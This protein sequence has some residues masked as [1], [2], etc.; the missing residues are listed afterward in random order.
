MC[1]ISTLQICNGHSEFAVLIMVILIM[2]IIMNMIKILNFISIYFGLK[3][4]Q[5]PS[6][7]IHTIL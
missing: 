7:H 3:F 6:Q 5:K 1:V 2:V 4:Q